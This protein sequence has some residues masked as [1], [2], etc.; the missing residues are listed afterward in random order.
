MPQK[1]KGVK[2]NAASPPKPPTQ[3]RLVLSPEEF[4]RVRKIAES[5]GLSMSAFIR[6]A[7]LKEVDRIESGR[8]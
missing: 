5:R 3:S 6:M 2:V 4:E 7:V 8:D 1:K